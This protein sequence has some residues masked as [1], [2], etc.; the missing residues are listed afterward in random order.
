[1]LSQTASRA[2]QVPT[3]RARRL[4]ETVLFVGVWMA[5][6]WVLRLE[7]DAYLLLGI[8]LTVAFQ[9][10][11]RRRAL[12]ALWVRDAPPLRL[13]AKGKLVA[14]ALMILPIIS[15]VQAA[16]A[17]QWVVVAWML[18]AMGGAVAAGYALR[19][20]RRD[21]AAP[22]L[23]WVLI[24]VLI[25]AA[26]MI[27]TIVGMLGD[28]LSP[29]SMLLNGLSSAVLYFAVSFVLEEVAFRGAVDAHIHEPGGRLGWPSALLSSALWGLWHAPIDPT[30]APLP[31][32]VV[33]LLVV[34]CA[35]GVP[36]AFAWRRSG[37]LA[38]PALAHA[39]IDGVRNGLL[40]GL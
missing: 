4:G 34:H 11:V 17:G 1:M 15:G 28:S 16:I 23:R 39:L 37:N 9:L 6:G 26:I 2:L 35:V 7:P 20:L 13:D 19:H 3:D 10:L 18:A 14:G 25:G 27:L 22:A 24:S 29:M 36:L 5:A 8:P 21:G 12:R 30:G 40:A 31:L 32:V 33:Q 38:Y